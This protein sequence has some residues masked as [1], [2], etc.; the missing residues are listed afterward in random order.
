VSIIACPYFSS[1]TTRFLVVPMILLAVLFATVANAG[2]QVTTGDILGTVKDPSGAVIPNALVT[3]SNTGTQETHTMHADAS[4]EYIFSLLQQGNYSVRVT[5]PGFQDVV[6]E[7]IALNAG[8]R[9]RADASLSLGENTQQVEV[10]SAPASLESDTSVLDTT[11][12]AKQAENL[13][14][15]GRNF[16]Q[17]AQLAAGANEATPGAISNGNRPDDRRQTSAISVDAQSDTLNNELVDGM[18]NNERVIGTIGVRPSIDA[19]AEVQVQTNLYPAEVGNTPGAV[20]NVITRSGENVL[21]GSVYEF[22]RNDVFDARDFFATVG[23]KP[24][25]RQ[26]QFGGSLGGPIRKNKMFFF[27]DY[28]GYRI[29]QGVTTVNTVPTLF[30]EQNPGNLSDIGGPV[31]PAGQLN[32]ISL[33]YLALYPA[34]NLPGTVNNFSYSPNNTQTSNTYD[35][36]VDQRFSNGDAIFVRYAYNG[37]YTNT[38]SGLPE[39]NGIYPGGSVSYPGPARDTAQQVVVNYVH[40]F[41]PTLLLQLAAGYTRINNQSLPLNYGQDDGT[42]MGVVNSNL[43]ELTSALPDVTIT[44]YSELGDSQWLPITDLDNTY[45]YAGSVTQT[46]GHHTLKYG[47]DLMRR[48]VEAE[49]NDQG[50]GAFSF[51]TSPSSFALDNFLTGSVYTVERNMQLDSP[52][53]RAWRYSAYVEDDWRAAPWL[54]LNLGLRYD[55]DTPDTEAHGYIS[56]FNPATAS[57]IIPGVNGGS[58]TAGVKTDYF[59]IAPRIGFAATLRKGTLVRGGFGLVYFRDDTSPDLPLS[60]APYAYSYAPEPFTTTFS[61]PLPLP[62]L[63][64]TT[65]LS[66]GIIGISTNYK[67]SRVEQFNLNVEQNVGKGTVLNLGYVGELGR[68]LRLSPD[69]DLAPP[70]PNQPSCTSDCFVTRMPFYSQLPN[71]SYIYMMQSGGYQDYHAL[72]GT[73]RQRMAYGVSG[74]FTYTWSHAI[75]DTVGY[76]EGG[77]YTSAVPSQTATLERGNSDL[78]MRDRATVLLNYELPFGK[79]LKGAKGVL[80]KGWQ[81]NAIDVWETGAPFSVA[82]ASPRSNTGI[83][84][85]RPNQVSSANLPNPSISEWFNTAAFQPQTFGTI[86]TARRDSVYGPHFRH[87]DASVFKNFSLSERY[88]LQLR[89]ESFNLTNTPSFSEPAATL[90]V[91]GFGTISSTRTGSTPRQLQFAAHITF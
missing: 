83:G 57:L 70:A 38:A 36:R 24:E 12:P 80:G 56:N 63:Q 73:V 26:N 17:L 59:P 37:V 89:A 58:A 20:V 69:I 88:T 50:P 9:Q 2:A 53:L 48:D 85:D 14:L 35:A 68:E 33:N 87:F 75:G 8:D 41:T 42:K 55:V 43:N 44:G 49:Q 91:P 81:F 34:P 4:G 74:I 90:G 3:L 72:Q 19:I 22:L 86:G 46:I 65:D 11:I 10:S 15:N 60:N 47:A 5:A 7:N 31:I 32:P 28:E 61:T 23:P 66:G 16:V 84:S 62:A 77:L 71:I 76:S 39:V 18:D 25:Y 21:H 51:I 82:N 29:V 13:P 79:S 52:N 6:V 40:T 67:D 30:E 27:G 45:Q 64:S 78:D 1:V 54:T